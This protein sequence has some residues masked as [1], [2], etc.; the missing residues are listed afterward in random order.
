MAGYIL[1]SG[2]VKHQRLVVLQAVR[3]VLHVAHVVA[4]VIQSI[5]P[6]NHH[7]SLRYR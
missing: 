2:L 3:V 7:C 1:V 4:R 5:V 6:A